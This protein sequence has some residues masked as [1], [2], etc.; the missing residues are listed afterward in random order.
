MRRRLLLAAGVA[1]PLVGVT[2][3]AG[4]AYAY[5]WDA[6][7][8]DV[9]AAGITVAGFDVGGLEAGTARA[10]LEKRLVEPLQEPVRVDYGSHSFLIRPGRAGVR[11]D[12]AHMVDTAVALGRR[13]NL[14]QRVLRELRGRRLHESVPLRAALQHETVGAFVDRVAR[15]VD[16]APR[17]ARVV[18]APQATTLRVAPSREG[19]AVRRG[20]LRRE[21]ASALLRFDGAR[22][23]TVPTRRLKARWTTE[24]VARRY[25]TLILVSRETF[26]LRLYKHLKLVK[27]YGI[28]VGRAGLETPAGFYRIDDKQ[29]NPSWHVP[30]SAWAGDLAG[31]IIPPGPQDPIKARWM[32]FYGG[33]GIHGTD[34]TWSIGT[35]ASHGCIRMTIPDVED[36]YARV[37]LHTPIYVG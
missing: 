27:R 9:I 16:V 24:N 7:R 21:V 4:G 31:R 35:A 5:F 22:T 18:P 10:L 33:A 26:T 28:A 34:A 30:N 3:S 15:I 29:V 11:V 1:L 13:G 32:G 2:L 17:Q 12:V 19:L 6:A 25:P 37:P 14:A 23:L 36:L 8:T 20:A